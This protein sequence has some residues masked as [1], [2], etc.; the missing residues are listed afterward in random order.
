MRVTWYLVGSTISGI[1]IAGGGLVP[2]PCAQAATGAL[3]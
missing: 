1:V 2:V 3:A